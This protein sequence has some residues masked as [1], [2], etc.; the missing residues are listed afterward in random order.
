ME[1]FRRASYNEK[2]AIVCDE[3]F[4][5]NLVTLLENYEERNH[6]GVERSLDRIAHSIRMATN[7]VRASQ[8]QNSYGLFSLTTADEAPILTRHSR[9]PPTPTPKGGR[10]KKQSDESGLQ[11]KRGGGR[12]SRSSGSEPVALPS[13]GSRG[14]VLY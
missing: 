4:L 7:D 8:G 11:L 9:T 5:W 14:F 13:G 3:S 1:Q 2:R 6:G 12:S 10:R